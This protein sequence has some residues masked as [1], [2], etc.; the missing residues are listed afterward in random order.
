LAPGKQSSLF[1]FSRQT[2]LAANP[3]SHN[4]LR[5]KTVARALHPIDTKERTDEIADLISAATEKLIQLST[6]WFELNDKE[7]LAHARRMLDDKEVT[8]MLSTHVDESGLAH[9]SLNLLRTKFPMPRP[10]FELKVPMLPWTLNPA[11]VSID[12]A[13][14]GG[15]SASNPDTSNRRTR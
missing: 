1:A 11:G 8:L 13:M 7:G 14:R 3:E 10:Y 5:R 9:V 2:F 15:G 4:R 6:E 12:A